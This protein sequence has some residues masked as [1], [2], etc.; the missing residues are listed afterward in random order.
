MYAPIIDIVEHALHGG[1]LMVVTLFGSYLVEAA[2]FNV[3]GRKGS[4][5]KHWALCGPGKLSSLPRS[6][7][8]LPSPTHAF[9]LSLSSPHHTATPRQMQL[10]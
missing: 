4:L 6:M 8:L 5:I 1:Q 9:L 10:S 7:E 3:H 2:K